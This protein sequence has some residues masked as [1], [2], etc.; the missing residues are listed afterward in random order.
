[1]FLVRCVNYRRH[2]AGASICL[3]KI[4]TSYEAELDS[5][6]IRISCEMTIYGGCVL[7]P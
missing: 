2:V 6:K 3:A 5:N 1:M 4:A 7:T